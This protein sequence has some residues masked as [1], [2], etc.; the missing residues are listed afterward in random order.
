MARWIPRIILL[1]AAVVLLLLLGA[2]WALRASL[3]QLEGT[4]AL[5]GLS[6]PV[7][8]ARDGL[9]IA[10]VD[11]ADAA[12]AMRA[13]GWV[14]AQER[15]F[16]MDLMRRSAAGELAALFG[17][18]ALGHDRMQ[19]VHRMRSRARAAFE[20]APADERD[21]LRAYAA[22]V[23]SGLDALRVRPWPY[24]LLRTRPT[25][26]QPEDSILV[27]YAMYFDLQDAGNTRE[28]A[29]WRIRPHLPDALHALL[30]HAGSSWDSPLVGAVVGDADLPG[31]EQ[32]DLRALPLPEVR[33]LR[34]D[35]EPEAVGSNNFAVDGTLTAHG[36]ALVADDMH[37]GLRAPGIW[38]RAR[39]RYRDPLAPGGA[40]DVSGFTLPGLP[41]VI[42]GSNGHV[43]WGFTNSYGDY[44]DWA[45]ETPCPRDPAG[46]EAA[47]GCAPMT[48]HRERIEVAGAEPEMIDI[49]E[50]A[51]GPVLHQAGDGRVLTLRWTAHL[52]G[53]IN[54]G[55]ADMARMADVER[56]LVRARDIALPT[57]NLVI[58]DSAGRIAW[59]LLGPVPV[60][61]PSCD[62][63]APV[64]PA[65]DGCRPWA[66][67]TRRGPTVASPT[68][69]RIWT[70]NARVVDGDGLATIGDGG[71]AL[72][73]RG[74]QIRDALQ[75]GVRFDEGDLLAIQLDHRAV[76]LERWHGLML[77]RARARQSPALQAL[78][79][80]SADWDGTASIGSVGYRLVRAWRIEV[81][82]RIVEGLLAPARARMGADF[83]APSL[84][85]LEGLAWPLVTRRPV[86]L[87]SPRHAD[88]DALFEEAAEAVR[89]DPGAAA[90]LSGR[91]W[92]EANTAHICHPLAEALPAILAR[93]L[94]MP[95]DP[96]PGDSHMP[97]VQAPAMGASQR[98][99]VAPGR[100]AEGIIHQPGGQSGHPLSP[101]W[102]AGHADWV[103]GRP[104]PFLP[105]AAI[106]SLELRP[107]DTR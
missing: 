59:R 41:A 22:G 68:A 33:G 50:S 75:A 88:W 54:L 90:P 99:V 17:P 91:S 104:S 65:T 105:G 34:V 13:L 69:D 46:Q 70:A 36:G 101:F 5:P 26:W 94:C 64:E 73:A 11:A 83:V 56:A 82:E 62:G 15:A 60:R 14:H 48:R 40:V 28:L 86:H 89:D 37:L 6:A 96:L 49:E 97:R 25:A 16:E 85:Q 71:Y 95:A 66:T 53:A 20:D 52:P 55:L 27:G 35:P 7:A 106:H 79:T 100:E 44:A 87:L 102:G 78:A 57:Q 42:V 67:S 24:L 12:D 4:G 92:G 74:A 98:M 61:D 45:L 81:N 10:T 80:A 30:A 107:A 58:G 31:P 63:S 8:I 43:A 9:G 39:L 18:R 72:G 76:F 23:N 29:L 103:H 77:D 93:R 51:W 1:L 21:L 84:P 3:P 38:F 32:V 19:R 47:P 2:W